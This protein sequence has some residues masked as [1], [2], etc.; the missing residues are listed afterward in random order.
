MFIRSHKQTFR[1]SQPPKRAEATPNRAAATA[2][3]PFHERVE[4]RATRKTPKAKA[5]VWISRPEQNSQMFPPSR[6]SSENPPE[7][8]PPPPPR[9]TRR[10][11][12]RRRGLPRPELLAAPSDALAHSSKC[13]G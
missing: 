5:A 1:S 12:R 6:R 4:Q 11:R 2:P 8:T 3:P 13:S 7:V 9:Q 10:A